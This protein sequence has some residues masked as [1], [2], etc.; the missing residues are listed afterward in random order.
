MYRAAKCRNEL[1]WYVYTNA[2][3]FPIFVN[4]KRPETRNS[5]LYFR[6]LSFLFDSLPACQS[7]IS[8]AVCASIII[9]MSLSPWF[10]F[11][12]P[13]MIQTDFT[14][15]MPLPGVGKCHYSEYFFSCSS[16]LLW[17][18]FPIIKRQIKHNA[19]IPTK[20]SA[21]NLAT[22]TESSTFPLSIAA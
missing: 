16:F 10:V 12:M 18:S 2:S 17:A 4:R 1:H 15:Y 13:V 19:V 11:S 9:W 5:F 7:T 14:S 21:A 20:K 8:S 22:G 3:Y 6:S